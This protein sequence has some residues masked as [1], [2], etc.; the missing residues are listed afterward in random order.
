VRVVVITAD[1]VVETLIECTA[2]RVIT[3]VPTSGDSITSSFCVNIEL[4]CI[5]RFS[6][7]RGSYSPRNIR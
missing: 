2:M 7:A 3:E 4:A 1:S 6:A 5:V